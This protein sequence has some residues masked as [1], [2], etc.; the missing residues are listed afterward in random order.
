MAANVR[1]GTGSGGSDQYHFSTRTYC[2]W[3]YMIANRD[4][5]DNKVSTRTVDCH[6]GSILYNVE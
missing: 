5:G 1:E 3:D 2:S 6:A 4:T